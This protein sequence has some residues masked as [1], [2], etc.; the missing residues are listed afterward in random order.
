MLARKIVTYSLTVL[1]LGTLVCLFG[2]VHSFASHD[3]EERIRF[4]TG[5]KWCFFAMAACAVYMAAVGGYHTFLALFGLDGGPGVL[6]KNPHYV[7][8]SDRRVADGTP[9]EPDGQ[10]PPRRSP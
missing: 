7:P 10:S 2:M 5:M 3:G 4:M 8:G 1:A 6:R 9:L